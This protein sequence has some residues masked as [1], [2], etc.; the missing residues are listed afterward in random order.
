MEDG[1]SPLPGARATFGDPRAE[2][3]TLHDIVIRKA[4]LPASPVV[5]VGEA[6]SVGVERALAA[7]KFRPGAIP[8]VAS[9][10]ASH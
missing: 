7:S 2:T 9:A 5:V 10:S 1:Y 4:S 6:V 3:G 8:E